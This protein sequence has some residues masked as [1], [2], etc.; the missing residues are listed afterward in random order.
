MAKKA[1]RKPKTA[2]AVVA[3]PEEF[4]PNEK[5]VSR[6]DVRLRMWRISWNVF[7]WIHFLLGGSAVLFSAIA[8]ASDSGKAWASV[9]AGMCVAVI[10][11]LRPETRYHN[12]VKGWRE[13]ENAKSRYV[14]GIDPSEKKLIAELARCEAIVTSDGKDEAVTSESQVA[15]A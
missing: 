8:A 5:L 10:G 12:A 1:V 4:T 3:E 7:L 2:K 11:F 9:T 15:S 13:L 6:V 14:F